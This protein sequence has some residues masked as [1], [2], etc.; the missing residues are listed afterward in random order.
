MNNEYGTENPDGK[1]TNL[2]WKVNEL[3]REPGRIVRNSTKISYKLSKNTIVLNQ[4]MVDGLIL[5]SNSKIVAK[6]NSKLAGLVHKGSTLI[7]GITSKTPH[8]LMVK[9]KK[10]EQD[11]QGNI[12]IYLRPASLTELFSELKLDVSFG[13]TPEEINNIECSN[14]DGSIQAYPGKNGW[15]TQLEMNGTVKNK[16]GGKNYLHEKIIAYAGMYLSIH[17][18]K[19]VLTWFS[20]RPVIEI[21]AQLEGEGAASYNESSSIDRSCRVHFNPISVGPV[22]LI[23]KLA[24]APV[25]KWHTGGPVWTY[26][27]INCWEDAVLTR[28]AGG[29]WTL[30]DS[31]PMFQARTKVPRVTHDGGMEILANISV[32]VD[33]NNI[34]EGVYG[35]MTP[36]IEFN[37]LKFKGPG[38]WELL[39]TASGAIVLWNQNID[40]SGFDYGVGDFLGI[41]RDFSCNGSFDDNT[42]GDV[43]ED[44]HSWFLKY[45][46]R[47]LRI[48]LCGDWTCDETI[49][50]NCSSC[51]KDCTCTYGQT[52]DQGKCTGTPKTPPR[53]ACVT[54]KQ[55]NDKYKKTCKD[56]DIITCNKL[57]KHGYKSVFYKDK[58]CQDIGLK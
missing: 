49:G 25:G 2:S 48:N 41:Q 39:G 29:K 44:H 31:A 37:S 3:D 23:P 52:C 22:V 9:V 15:S 58:T 12:I 7:A 18:E 43:V 42:C 47:I 56:T 40:D 4:E 10:I 26:A 27:T 8:G 6:E 13:L 34:G 14:S 50:E 36:G 57:S 38:L 5:I 16:L 55:W 19:S 20:V 33:F 32:S 28:D 54:T 24:I 30:S 53:G 51:P 45:Y 46:K 21:M 17:I 1:N 35:V 11:S